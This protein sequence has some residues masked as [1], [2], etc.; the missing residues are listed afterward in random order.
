MPELPEVEEAMQRLRAAMEG[1]TIAKAKAIH[2]ALV[3]Q[4]PDTAAR[5]VKGKRIERVEQLEH[6]Q[7]TTHLGALEMPDQVPVYGEVRQGVALL[8]QLLHPVLA[9]DRQACRERRTRRLRRVALRDR[10]QGDLP[11]VGPFARTLDARPY[12][13]EI[14]PQ[15]CVK[16]R[17]QIVGGHAA[18]GNAAATCPPRGRPS[19]LPVTAS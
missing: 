17:W 7:C 15:P 11:A 13:R 19:D 2:P 8:L 18:N 14:L 12:L 3:R 10:D 9:A 16:H 6:R 4:F 5:R 1:K